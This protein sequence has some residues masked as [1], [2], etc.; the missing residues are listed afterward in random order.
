MTSWR[1]K[2]YQITDI[3]K[4]TEKSYRIDILRERYNEASLKK[5]NLTM[6]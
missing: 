1:N 4:D 6:K 5:T 2:L 3:I